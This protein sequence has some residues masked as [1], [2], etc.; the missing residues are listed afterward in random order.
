MK[1]LILPAFLL[2]AGAAWGQADGGWDRIVSSE[3]RR[4]VVD[5]EIIYGTKVDFDAWTI[6]R[7]GF[8]Q[9]FAPWA[10]RKNW[11][12]YGYAVPM[13]MN[14]E[15]DPC[16]LLYERHPDLTVGKAAMVLSKQYDA[17]PGPTSF[18]YIGFPVKGVAVVESDALAAP[19]GNRVVQSAPEYPELRIRD[20]C[21]WIREPDPFAQPMLRIDALP[22][23]LPGGVWDTVEFDGQAPSIEPLTLMAGMVG[24]PAD[25]T[26]IAPPLVWEPETAGTGRR[27]VWTPT[28]VSGDE[29]LP[30]SSAV[31]NGDVWWR[32]TP[33]DQSE[34]GVDY[35]LSWMPSESEV[36]FADTTWS[37]PSGT[38]RWNGMPVGDDPAY[39]RFTMWYAPRTDPTAH[40]MASA[41]AALNWYLL[42]EKPLPRLDA[43]IRFEFHPIH[44]R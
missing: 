37:S 19:A 16:G 40:V 14:R 3:P 25:G 38:M 33:M 11:P 29:G 6:L 43:D 20:V 2:V 21:P 41:Q 5:N 26:G 9:A 13:T 4:V 39:T 7:K 44:S 15:T 12:F 17:A 23:D 1:Q 35:Y 42:T 28:P 18:D 10:F 27:I 32:Y 8:E 34:S 36:T 22:Y 31:E 24:G 30:A